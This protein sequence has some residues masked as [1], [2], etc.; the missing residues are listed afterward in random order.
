[1]GAEWTTLR[2]K[3]RESWG[4]GKADKVGFSGPGEEGRRGRR[5]DRKPNFVAYSA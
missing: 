4:G 1:M 3:G 2:R 5:R